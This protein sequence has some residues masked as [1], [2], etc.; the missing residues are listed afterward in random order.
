MVEDAPITLLIVDGLASGA[1]GCNDYTSDVQVDG[2]N[3]AFGT[4][5]RR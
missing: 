3:I 2:T 1:A 4:P 5:R